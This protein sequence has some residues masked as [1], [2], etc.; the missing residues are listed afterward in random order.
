MFRSTDGPLFWLPFCS[1]A[2]AV[3]AI[4]FRLPCGYLPEGILSCARL[5][6]Q[7]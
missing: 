4:P 7:L 2:P 1:V 5:P 3:E 6:G